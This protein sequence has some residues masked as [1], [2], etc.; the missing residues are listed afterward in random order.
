MNIKKS[1]QGF[2]LI[3]IL[4]AVVVVSVG[5]LGVAAMQTLGVRYTQNSY[6]L[7]IA[8]QQ[9]QDM[10][11]RI[12]SNPAEMFNTTSGYYNNVSGTFG[13]TKPDCTTSACTSLQ[14]AQLDHAEWT[15]TNTTIFGEAG[16]V[17]RTTDNNFLITIDWE[18]VQTNGST[19]REDKR[20]ILSF[21]P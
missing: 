5:V 9:A 12:R 10:A 4:I 3:E 13:G 2:T 18:D 21:Q 20:F 19:G 14:R 17:S 6:M 8:T 1:Q 16:S 11:E 15:A 7:S